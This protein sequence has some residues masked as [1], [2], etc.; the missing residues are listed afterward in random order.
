MTN[1]TKLYVG[2]I[3]TEIIL[4]TKTDISGASSVAIKYMK[5][6]TT[7]I[8]SWVGTILDGTKVRY[9]LQVDDIDVSGTWKIM[10]Y[11]NMG[12]WAGHGETV[13]L[14]VYDLMK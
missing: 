5:P 1:E 2:D 14:S 10:A 9:V 12:A 11:V 6:G 3:G 7:S 4:D 13:T 8:S